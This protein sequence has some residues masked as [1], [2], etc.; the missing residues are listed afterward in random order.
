MFFAPAHYRHLSISCLQFRRSRLLMVTLDDPSRHPSIWRAVYWWYCFNRPA[1]PSFSTYG[2]SFRYN[3]VCLGVQTKKYFIFW[4]HVRICLLLMKS[5]VRVRMKLASTTA[6]HS[7]FWRNKDM[8]F[9]WISSPW[10]VRAKFSAER[11]LGT[12]FWPSFG[13]RTSNI[14]KHVPRHI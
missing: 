11:W 5:L 4:S 6:I 8:V 14:Y 3:E 9:F 13:L 7:N 1:L 10:F 2:R 12:A